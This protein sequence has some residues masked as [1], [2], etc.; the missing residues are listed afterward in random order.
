[1]RVGE[2]TIEGQIREREQA[3]AEYQQAK[4]SGKKASLVE[5]E[6]PNIFTTSVANLGPGEE[7]VV[8]IELQETLDFD[9]GEVRLRF[10]LVV[11][12]R[13][14]PGAEILAG[15]AG[16]GWSPDTSAGAGRLARSRRRCC[17]RARRHAT[18][19]GSTSSSTPASRSTTLASRYHAIVSERRDESRYH[20]RLRDE[21]VPADRDFELVWTPRPGTMPRGAV[22]ARSAGAR[23]TRS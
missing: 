21:L 4:A 3:R 13:Y 15:L 18:R 8:E 1:M 22:F 6:R 9:E 16:V 11:G 20:V 14:V 12:P 7:L 2:R 10:P 5:Q 17:R 23:P 19:C